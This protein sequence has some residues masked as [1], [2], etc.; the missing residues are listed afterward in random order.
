[1]RCKFPTYFFFI[2]LTVLAACN[3]VPSG[4]LSEKEMAAVMADVSL[5]EV[6]ITDDYNAYIK[7]GAKEALFT[8]VFQKHHITQAQYDSSVVWYGRNI[9]IYVRVCDAAATELKRRKNALGD[10]QPDAG[11]VED[12]DSVNI[13]TRRDYIIFQ[14]N[15]PGI[16]VY[17]DYNPSRGYLSGSQF[18]FSMNVWGLTPDM[19]HYPVVRLSL[20]QQDTTTTVIEKI[21]KDGMFEMLASSVPTKRVRRVYGYIHFDYKDS[22]SHKIYIDSIRLMRYNYGKEILLNGQLSVQPENKD[23]M[24][25]DTLKH[26]SPA[27]LSD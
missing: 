25:V 17:F 10:I 24:A 16:G 12:K 1:M 14:K 6:M 15:N 26:V 27:Q 8:S 13:W 7:E 20:E 11:P 5:A 3:K 18:V 21:T 9:D 19:A 4:I 2:C 22:Q 23:S